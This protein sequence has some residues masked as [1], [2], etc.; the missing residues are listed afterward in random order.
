M[1][2]QKFLES[3]AKSSVSEVRVGKVKAL[4]GTLKNGDS[5]K[6]EQVGSEVEVSVNNEMIY[7]YSDVI[8]SLE[9]L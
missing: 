4:E 2:I 1:N 8:K 9:E 3:V 6:V 7:S 5:F